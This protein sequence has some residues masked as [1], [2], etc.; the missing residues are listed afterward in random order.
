MGRLAHR[1][2]AGLLALCQFATPMLLP[3]TANA[4][5]ALPA[6][7]D[8]ASDDLT[9]AAEKRLGDRIMLEVRRDPDV[10]DDPL[11]L[12]YVAQ[13]FA[14]LVASARARGEIS[15]DL[16]SHYNFETFLVRD[17]SVNAFALPGGHIG[18]HLGLISMTGSRDEL[19][20][21]LAHELSHVTQ[22]HIARMVAV[23]RRQTMVGLASFILGVMAASRSPD[24]ANALIMGGQGAMV[25]GQLNFSRDMEREADRV[26]FGV[27]EEAGYAGV[28]MVGMF[29]RLQ[30]SSRL[31]SQQFPYLRSHPLTGERIGEARQR[32]GVAGAG[33]TLATNSGGTPARWLH[34]AMQGRARAL[35]DG[36]GE[37]LKRLA[38]AVVN[39]SNDTGPDALANAYAAG[40]AATRLKD[41]NAADTALRRALA[42]ARPYD[43]AYRAV[44]VASI[45]S[46]VERG[47][48]ADALA[49]LNARLDDG[50]RTSLLLG[51]NAVLASNGPQ[52]SVL[53]DLKPRTEALQTWVALHPDDATVWQ[54]L[55]QLLERRGQALA[56][57]RAQAEVQLA[58][59]N[60]SGAADRLRAGQRMA[61]S[62][63]QSESVE[64]AV[65]DARLTAVELRRKREQADERMNGGEPR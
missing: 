34:A 10:I 61:R 29:E 21:V 27:L 49:L 33:E 59:G 58:F 36:R 19:A 43:L 8:A 51:A 37:A 64:A 5:N 60:L 6:L 42:L 26:G 45:E 22:R 47:R 15:E 62:T 11:L 1:M 9:V 65:I 32:L 24:A 48:A 2:L 13:T 54:T 3:G 17:R 31:D 53:A 44:E 23:N 12:D 57:V 41:W 18:V 30:Q 25:Q 7:G 39:G 56:S 63:G 35:M 52:V 38:S 28:G 16:Q 20:A 40:L 50:S 46:L 55:S 4:A 14:P